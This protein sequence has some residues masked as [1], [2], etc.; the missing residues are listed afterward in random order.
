MTLFAAGALTLAACG[1]GGY[2]GSGASSSSSGASGASAASGG[3]ASAAAAATDLAAWESPLGAIVVDGTGRT[4]YVFDKDTAGAAASACTGPCVSLWPA[5]TT[6]SSAP[7]V[8]GVTGEVGTAPT[9]DGKEQVTLDGH[10]LYTFS[11]DSGTQQMNGQGYMGLWWAV[12]PD[13]TK[14]TATAASAVPGY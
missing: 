3:S 11:G 12:A 2:G 4:L 6:T 9:A 14:V 1:S 7:S 5:L 10:R 8:S 13:G